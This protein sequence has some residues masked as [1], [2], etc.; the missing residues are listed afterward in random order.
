[1]QNGAQT[2]RLKSREC[3]I[4][5]MSLLTN[6]TFTPLFA[7]RS[8]LEQSSTFGKQTVVI[9]LEVLVW[10]RC[11]FFKGETNCIEK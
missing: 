8:T 2:S 10:Q 11:F 6:E 4:V 5:V 3:R 9:R 7:A 1:M